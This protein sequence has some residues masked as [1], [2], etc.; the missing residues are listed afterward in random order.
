MSNFTVSDS[1]TT[2]ITSSEFSLFSQLKFLYGILFNPIKGLTQ[3]ERL[4]S[5]YKVQAPIYD[6][7]RERLLKGREQLCSELV[8]RKCVRGDWLDI[9]AGT[10]WNLGLMAQKARNCES[11]T[12]IDLSLSLIKKA[13]ERVHQLGLKN[14]T[15]LNEDILRFKNSERQFDL[16]TLSY[17]LTMIPSWFSVLEK[18]FQMLAPG[19]TIGVTDFYVSQKHRLDGQDSHSWFIRSFLPIFFAFDDV[20]LSPDYLLWLKSHFNSDLLIESASSLP[21]L[22]W[23]K[24][25]YFVFIGGK[26]ERANLHL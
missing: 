14:V 9:G 17:S 16:I 26:N 24:A 3:S 20:H 12:L 15:L 23:V 25:P 5:F 18:A 6:V 4:E 2:E 7:S 8:S 13:E 10:G 19:G 22:P 21:Y 1:S 11:I